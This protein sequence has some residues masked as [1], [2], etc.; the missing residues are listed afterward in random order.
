MLITCPSCA[1]SY[2]LDPSSLGPAGGSLHCGR[3][4]RT[5]FVAN[6]AAMLAIEQGYRAEIAEFSR[7]LTARLCDDGHFLEIERHDRCRGGTD[8]HSVV[9]ASLEPV[10]EGS[11]RSVAGTNSCPFR[12]SVALSGLLRKS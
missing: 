9:G 6:T 7:A 3:C 4:G 8:A 2:E 11:T 5:W 12:R 10:E 1:G